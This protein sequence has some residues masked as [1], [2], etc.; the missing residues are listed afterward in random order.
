MSWASTIT[1]NQSRKNLKTNFKAGE[2]GFG[3]FGLKKT[4]ETFDG[5][6]DQVNRAIKMFFEASARIF[7][8]TSKG[9]KMKY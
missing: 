9:E 6:L 8:K 1:N 3:N 7:D 5:I 2:E 4:T